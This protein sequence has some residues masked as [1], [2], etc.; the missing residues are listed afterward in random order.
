MSFHP[1][2]QHLTANRRFY[3]FTT[4]HFYT[5]FS[6]LAPSKEG[7]R[8]SSSHTIILIHHQRLFIPET[9]SYSESTFLSLH[10]IPFPHFNFQILL[11]WYR[12]QR[13][14]S[15]HKIVLI[16]QECIFQARMSLIMIARKTR[17]RCLIEASVALHLV[18][19]QRM[20]F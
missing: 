19:Y 16:R 15:S 4:F 5:H 17:R 9:T 7:Q 11:R 6:N 1:R 20:F 8:L 2:K 13:L 3:H 12:R 10:Y 14:S 18:R